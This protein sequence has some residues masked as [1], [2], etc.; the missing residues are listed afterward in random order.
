M[1]RAFCSVIPV[2]R[3]RQSVAVGRRT[4]SPGHSE[5][6]GPLRMEFGRSM[7]GL[8]GFDFRGGG[9]DPT[10]RDHADLPVRESPK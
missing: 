2:G 6:I 8:I 7:D 5:D 4:A 1:A 3:K 10:A 9:G